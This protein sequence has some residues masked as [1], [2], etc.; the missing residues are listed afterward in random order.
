[1]DQASYEAGFQ[2]AMQLTGE[3]RARLRGQPVEVVSTVLTDLC[4]SFIAGYPPDMRDE[5]FLFLY[6]AIKDRIP[7]LIEEMIARGH[8]A[9]TWRGEPKTIN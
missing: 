2:A 5:R 9:A 6:N 1:M 3:F 4:A 8:V 7:F